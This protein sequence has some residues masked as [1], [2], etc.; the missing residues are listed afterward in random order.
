[1]KGLHMVL[2]DKMQQSRALNNT[3]LVI[4][5]RYNSGTADDSVDDDM[6]DG[7]LLNLYFT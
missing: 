3:L 1:M 7:N 6:D 4:N 5:S 2:R